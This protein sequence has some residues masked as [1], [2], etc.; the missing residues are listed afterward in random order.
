MERPSPPLVLLVIGA[1]R[2]RREVSSLLRS[3]GFGVVAL[4]SVE[5]VREVLA[6]VV[7]RA[8]VVDSSANRPSPFALLMEVGHGRPTPTVLVCTDGDS[9]DLAERFDV[10]LLDLRFEMAR[11]PGAVREAI[12]HVRCPTSHRSG[13]TFAAASPST[14][15]RGA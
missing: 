15:K 1:S 4:S 7:P 14:V 12:R 13:S 10:D 9:A 5:E 8:L 6:L 3:A 11:L 2:V